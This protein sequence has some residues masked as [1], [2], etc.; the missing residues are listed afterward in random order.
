MAMVACKDTGLLGQIFKA[1]D[2]KFWAEQPH[3][4]PQDAKQPIVLA[5]LLLLF[6]HLCAP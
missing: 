6:F 3:S 4:A 2:F 1:I 5:A